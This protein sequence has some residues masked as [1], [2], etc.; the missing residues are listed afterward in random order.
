MLSPIHYSVCSHCDIMVWPVV[1]CNLIYF[2]I[3]AQLDC[4]LFLFIEEQ[5]CVQ[6]SGHKFSHR[7]PHPDKDRVI[8]SEHSP[9]HFHSQKFLIPRP[10]ISAV[11][12]KLSQGL[13]TIVT[14]NYSF[15][16]CHHESA[17]PGNI[18]SLKPSSDWLTG[19]VKRA[20]FAVWNETLSTS[21]RDYDYG[22]AGLALSDAFQFCSYRKRF[23]VHVSMHLCVCVVPSI[24]GKPELLAD[25]EANNSLTQSSTVCTYI[26]LIESVS[27]L[28]EVGSYKAHIY[29]WSVPTVITNKL[30]FVLQWTESREKAKFNHLKQGSPKKFTLVYIS[31]RP[32]F[33]LALHFLNCRTSGG[34]TVC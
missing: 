24:L 31:V 17:S 16:A 33:L 4:I 10:I 6:V 8:H 32:P 14:F 5:D 3:T 1:S 28:F 13:S 15:S 34:S 12:S 11:A 27:V 20:S 19:L 7:A 22:A 9:S 30:S 2:L 29:S 23:C 26:D 25:V 18:R 21:D